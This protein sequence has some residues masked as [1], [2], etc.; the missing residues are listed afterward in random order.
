MVKELNQY[1]QSQKQETLSLFHT[2]TLLESGIIT[3]Q[4]TNG[5][6]TGTGT[7]GC[8]IDLDTQS[9]IGNGIIF[10]GIIIIGIGGHLLDRWLNRRQELELMDLEDK[11]QD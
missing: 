2:E 8:T 1:W 5:I 11:N 4:D 7:T 3:I 6:I 10:I 9:T